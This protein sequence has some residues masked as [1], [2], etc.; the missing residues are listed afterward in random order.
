MSAI[1]ETPTIFEHED[2]D[3]DT[4]TV[5]AGSVSV[6]FEARTWDDGAFGTVVAKVAVRHEKLP[7][8]LA[9]LRG[10]AEQ[11]VTFP[12][13]DDLARELFMRDNSKGRPEHLLNDWIDLSA[14]GDTY[15]HHMAD[16]AIEAFRKANS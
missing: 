6:I 10:A 8:L 5:K 12:D 13:R 3:G 16:A 2:A 4:L 1:I 9:A 7:E 14:H 15:A 11:T